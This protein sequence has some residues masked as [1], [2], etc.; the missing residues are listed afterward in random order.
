MI[1]SASSAASSDTSVVWLLQ[2]DHNS[3]YFDNIIKFV[4]SP[5]ATCSSVISLFFLLD[6]DAC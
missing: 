4:E 5:Y 6:L 3:S 2:S 1:A